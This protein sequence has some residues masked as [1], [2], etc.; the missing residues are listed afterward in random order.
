[1][2]LAG[3]A[4]L[5]VQSPGYS[6][7]ARLCSLAW[8]GAGG[9]R[10]G[11]SQSSGDGRHL[12]WEHCAR[13]PCR[14]HPRGADSWARCRC[15]IRLYSSGLAREE[16]VLDRWGSRAGAGHSPGGCL[17]RDT[18]V[19]C[20]DGW[21][22]GPA[23]LLGAPASGRVRLGQEDTGTTLPSVHCPIFLHR[24]R[25]QAGEELGWCQLGAVGAVQLG[26]KEPGQLP[27]PWVE[28]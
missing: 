15:E 27:L 7:G 9:S 3:L 4:S 6:G 21:G 25:Q 22:P 5:A 23:P 1:M 8:R 13:G 2:G 17:A 11:R 20:S 24:G 26:N 16:S 18:R 10:V 12:R 19:H 14:Y 28:L